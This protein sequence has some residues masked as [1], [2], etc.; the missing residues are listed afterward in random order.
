MVIID[1][2]SVFQPLCTRINPNSDV[3][4]IGNAAAV[5]IFNRWFSSAAIFLA[6][7][8]LW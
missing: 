6:V 7:A 2:G 5:A 8:Y 4:V 3:G 1:S